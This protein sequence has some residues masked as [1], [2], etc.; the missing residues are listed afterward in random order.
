[1]IQELMN[2]NPHLLFYGIFAIAVIVLRLPLIGRYFRTVNTLLHE[3]GHALAAI[4]T[5]GEV[6]HVELNEDTSGTALTKSGSKSR[7][8]LVSFAG[9]PFAALASGILIWLASTNQVKMAF[10]ILLSIALLNLMLFVRNTYGLVWL[11]TFS[12]LIVFIAW[13]DKA[14]L[15]RISALAISLIAFAETIMSTLYILF[16]GLAHPRKAGDL[17]NL[18]RISKVPAVIWAVLIAGMVSIIVYYTVVSNF[19][20]PLQPIVDSVVK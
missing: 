15:S 4:L 5:S 11:L 17:T 19:P 16:L 10:L 6:V 14:P 20:D 9:Y 2:R 3:S 12:G 7:A 18:A 1:M 13:V 8:I